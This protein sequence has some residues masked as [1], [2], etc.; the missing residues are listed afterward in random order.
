V[1]VQK[2]VWRAAAM[3][4]AFASLFLTG[5]AMVG[6]RALRADQMEYARALG[7]GKKREILALAV[8]LRYADLPGFLNVSQIIAAYT[9]DAGATA[10]TNSHPGPAASATGTLAYGD[11]PTLTFAPMTGEYFARG[12]IHPLAPAVILP[13]ANT[14]VPVDLLMRISVQSVGR[15]QNATMLGGPTGAGS[16][17][18]FELLH[19]LRRL[20]LAGEISIRYKNGNSDGVILTLGVSAAPSATTANDIARIRTLLDLPTSGHDFD[21]VPGTGS[22]SSAPGQI[23]MVTRSVLSILTAMGGEIS[24]P[25]ADVRSGA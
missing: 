22:G 8:G 19:I 5:C 12:Y 15:L 20:Q 7:E 6:P 18:F 13:L 2:V 9:F 1:D 4:C 14:G 16:A 25:D 23:A 11:H 3:T 24:V 21:L 10:T 17:E